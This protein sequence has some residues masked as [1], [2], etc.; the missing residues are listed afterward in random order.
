MKMETSIRILKRLMSLVLSVC[1]VFCGVA[2]TAFATEDDTVL[3]TDVEYTLP[4]GEYQFTATNDGWY[5][6][7]STDGG[8]PY[9]NVALN[10]DEDASYSDDD[11]GVDNNFRCFIEMSSGDVATLRLTN[12][13]D[14]DLTEITFTITYVGTERPDDS[15]GDIDDDYD[16]DEPETVT[17]NGFT[18]TV[19]GDTCEITSIDESAV[20]NNVLSVP[21]TISG[22]YVEELYIW[23]EYPV[24]YVKIINLPSSLKVIPYFDDWN[25]LSE[26]NI[27]ENNANYTSV[28]GVV[29]NKAMTEV[30]CVP[31]S[32][33]GVFF[34]P[35]NLE[36]LVLRDCE[37]QSFEI[38]E[39]NRHFSLRNGILCNYGGTIFIKAS[40]QMPS[41]FVLIGGVTVEPGCFSGSELSSLTISSDV[42]SISY[43]SFA[44]CSKL[45]SVNIPGTVKTIGGAAF[46]GC[47]NLQEVVLSNG[48]SRISLRAF[49]NCTS[50]TSVTLPDTVKYIGNGAFA[51]CTSLTGIKIPDSTRNIQQ[52]VFNGCTS[53]TSVIIPD[54]VTSIGVMAFKGCTSLTGI[55]IPDSVTSIETEAFEKCTS[56]TSVTIPDSVTNIDN[57]AFRNCTSLTSVTIPESVTSIGSSAFEDCTSLASITIPESVKEIGWYA[58]SGCKSLERVTIPDGITSLSSGIF[59][60][61]ESL[62]IMSSDSSSTDEVVYVPASVTGM[63][64]DAHFLNCKSIKS[65]VLQEGLKSIG[66]TSFGGC[67]ALTDITIPNSIEFIYPGAFSGCSAL[68]NITIGDGASGFSADAFKDTAYYNNEANWENGVLYIGNHLVKAKSTIAG[69]YAVKPGTKSIAEDAF[70]NCISLTGVTIPDSVINIGDYAFEGCTSLAN[71]IIP[72]GVV[73]VGRNA[74]ADTGYY[75]NASNWEN[76]VLYIGNYLVEARDEISGAYTVKNGTRSILIDAFNGCASLAGITLPDSVTSIGESAFMGCSSL[77]SLTIPESVT[78]VGSSAFNSCSSLTSVTIPNGITHLGNGTFS[79]CSSLASLTIPVSVTSIGGWVFSGC[80]SLTSITIPAGV[81]SIENATFYSCSSLT[82]ITIPDSVMSIGDSAFEDCTS[83]TNVTIPGSITEI[84]DFAFSGCTSLTSITIP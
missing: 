15:W 80:S 4:V 32:F 25:N 35:R 45:T 72:D 2:T 71:I 21:E 63:A 59:K 31:T 47:S 37:P 30:V 34:I 46:A 62:K 5:K 64:Y 14:E 84:K 10:G 13:N 6:L 51:Y 60:N 20:V 28:N 26:I 65:V 56:L 57:S 67:T 54:S 70:K 73:N 17:E 74:F 1:I 44:G 22:Y 49:K 75:N 43:A 61:C 83:L 24:D 8:D 48:V 50:L 18:A 78:S 68:T 29:Y 3:I 77:A 12:Y 76:D 27:A 55:T 11:Y 23:G 16:Y 36:N 66:V 40:K 69:N 39:G 19:T 7:E 33:N 82:N 52:G 38:E 41:E 53:L 9:I 79:G 81:T 58:F 42:T